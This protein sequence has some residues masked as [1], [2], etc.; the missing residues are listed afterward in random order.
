MFEVLE[1]RNEQ[2]SKMP[3]KESHALHFMQRNDVNFVRLY[4]DEKVTQVATV[5]SSLGCFVAKFDPNDE[6]SMVIEGRTVDMM[7]L[8]AKL[9]DYASLHSQTI[10]SV[11][12]VNEASDPACMFVDMFPE[13]LA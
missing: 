10:P 11:K 9:E 4:V 5:S 3:F 12:I 13:Y 1:K 8:R 2:V 7:D 6:C